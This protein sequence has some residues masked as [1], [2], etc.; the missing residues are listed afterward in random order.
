MLF[1][2]SSDI[3]TGK[4]RWLEHVVER[5]AAD[6]VRVDGVLAPGVW[7]EHRDSGEAEVE[8]E[9]IAI[10]NVLLPQGERILFARRRDLAERDGE[11]DTSSQAAAANI[12]WAIDET[13]FTQVNAH[14]LALGNDESS[15]PGLLVIDE[16]GRIELE[17]GGGLTAA[18]EVV[19]RG[20]TPAHP[21]AL[22][23][24]RSR[25]LDIALERFAAAS[26]G[27]MLP[28]APDESGEQLLRQVIAASM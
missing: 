3:G 21:H 18:L 22:A 11:Y 15:E 20:A 27:G 14:L 13:A 1:L 24:V 8:R 17:R 28:I 23:V 7:L 10:E 25:L 19:E 6:G 2:L 5:I 12:G 16:I 4:T 26:W 9:K